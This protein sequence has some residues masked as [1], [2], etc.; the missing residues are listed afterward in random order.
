MSLVQSD[1]FIVYGTAFENGAETCISETYQCV[2]FDDITLWDGDTRNIHHIEFGYIYCDSE[3][4]NF[5][6]EFICKN[7]QYL[8]NL[9]SVSFN[10]QVSDCD[11]IWNFHESVIDACI[12]VNFSCDETKVVYSF[13][14]NNET[15]K[16][17]PEYLTY[18][19][20]TSIY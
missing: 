16:S 17:M 9:Q 3:N 15:K 6:W 8:M 11:V 14:D 5:V 7:S 1:S 19:A 4:D 12:S 2:R 20:I 10:Q 18:K 13:M